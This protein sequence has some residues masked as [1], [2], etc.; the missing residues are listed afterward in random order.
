MILGP[1]A[2]TC[3]TDHQDQF[4]HTE[5]YIKT[6]W[7]ALNLFIAPI[8]FLPFTLP[9][10]QALKLRNTMQLLILCLLFLISTSVG[11]S[12]VTRSSTTSEPT[13]EISTTF[14]QHST[15]SSRP[16][17]ASSAP[18]IPTS[19]SLSPCATS[20]LSLVA[21]ASLC[22]VPC[23]T[24]KHLHGSTCTDDSD[25][26]V[27]RHLCVHGCRFPGEFCLVP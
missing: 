16:A 2:S 23:V 7:R 15:R 6:A 22:N 5:Q 24:P 21:T 10:H 13:T 18:A 12:G 14:F 11:S 1:V 3:Y 9:P 4:K 17:P 25:M 27:Q 26:Q 8:A 19:I 20:C